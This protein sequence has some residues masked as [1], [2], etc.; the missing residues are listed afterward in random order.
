LAEIVGE[1]SAH[2]RVR[3]AAASAASRLCGEEISDP[4]ADLILQFHRNKPRVMRP[5]PEYTDVELYSALAE[6]RNDEATD[7][8]VAVMDRSKE[9]YILDSII[10]ATARRG[11]EKLKEA[12]KR[13][14]RKSDPE[15]PLETRLKAARTLLDLREAPDDSM[16]DKVGKL[17]ASAEADGYPPQVVAEARKLKREYE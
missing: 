15:V 3:L 8:I 1:G 16:R 5:N 4:A 11:D 7:I 10:S 2:P 6:V 12:L 17:A 13:V 14:V 9:G